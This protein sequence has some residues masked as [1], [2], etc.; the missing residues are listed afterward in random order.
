MNDLDIGVWG[1]PKWKLFVQWTVGRFGRGPWRRQPYLR[2]GLIFSLGGKKFLGPI[3]FRHRWSLFL[4]NHDNTNLS[5]SSEI[6][7]APH[8]DYPNPV[9]F[10]WQGELARPFLAD[11]DY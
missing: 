8:H 6:A 11:E 9:F 3:V 10:L 7:R 2:P 4:P 5:L 1:K